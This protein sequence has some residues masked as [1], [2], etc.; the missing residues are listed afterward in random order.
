MYTVALGK[1][2][3]TGNEVTISYTYRILVQRHGHLL[4]LDLPRPTKGL[5]V[6]L[7][8]GQAG[9]RYVNVLDYFASP[10]ASRVELSSEAAPTR[11]ID[12]GFDGWVFPR[13]GMASMWVLQDEL[14][15]TAP[16]SRNFN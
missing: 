2:A 14:I 15:S 16:E 4:Y 11:T 8:Y 10:G 1:T 12:I 3:T 5:H 7:N 9:I 13:A 6:Q